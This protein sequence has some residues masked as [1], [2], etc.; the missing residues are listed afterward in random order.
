MAETACQ[1]G[2]N[3]DVQKADMESYFRS[4]RLAGQE[5]YSHL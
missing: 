2:S 3:A 4:G 1:M 5:Y